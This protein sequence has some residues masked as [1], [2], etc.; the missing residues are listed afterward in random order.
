MAALMLL[1]AVPA[2]A[3]APQIEKIA[4]VGNGRVEVEFARDVRYRN[5]PVK[6]INEN[7]KKH[8]ATVTERDEGSV[9]ARVAG[10]EKGEKYAVKVFGVRKYGSTGKYKTL[11]YE[12]TARDD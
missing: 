12:F 6:V 10:L 11:T 1:G 2:L 4:Y 5:F 9:E 8:S 7:G 3:D